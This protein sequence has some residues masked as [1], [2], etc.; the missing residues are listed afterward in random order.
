MPTKPK[1]KHSPIEDFS[2]EDLRELAEDRPRRKRS[3]ARRTSPTRKLAALPPPEA[4]VAQPAVLE[5]QTPAGPATMAAII[6]EVQILEHHFA[7]LALECRSDPYIAGAAKVLE[8]LHLF[9]ATGG[10]SGRRDPIKVLNACAAE[11][12]HEA[13]GKDATSAH[14][15]GELGRQAVQLRTYFERYLQLQDAPHDPEALALAVHCARSEAPEIVPQTDLNAP[16]WAPWAAEFRWQ[17]G[18]SD[19]ADLAEAIVIAAAKASKVERPSALF[20]LEKNRARR[21]K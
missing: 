14:V 3:A 18:S 6:G 16:E 17:L 8:G 11:L 19:R 12:L 2:D 13:R 4:P 1:T 9:L 15:P 20:D 21:A 10:G 7:A 5:E